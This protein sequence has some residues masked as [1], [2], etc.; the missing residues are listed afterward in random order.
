MLQDNVDTSQLNKTNHSSA[1]SSKVLFI[2][3]LSSVTIAQYRH[4]TMPCKMQ[5]I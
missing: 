1:M 4:D 2:H 3:V 5:H